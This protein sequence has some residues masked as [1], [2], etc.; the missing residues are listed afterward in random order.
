VNKL[1]PNIER[2]HHYHAFEVY[3]DL[4]YGR[5]YREVAR[6]IGSS[7]QSVCKWAKIYKWEDRLKECREVAESP[8]AD[9][10]VVKSDDPV[11]R[12]MQLLVEQTEALIDTVFQKDITGKIISKIKISSPEELI[13]LV[14][15][16]RK[17]LEAYYRFE[18]EYKPSKAADKRATKID[19]LTAVFMGGASQEERIA[20][21]ESLKNGNVPGRDSGAAGRLQEADYTE[22]PERGDAD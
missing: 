18:A 4:G 14:S 20:M 5:S 6:Q 21:M 3:R 10:A 7:A 13:R 22:V 17:M 15:E 9:G 11:L 19:K 16:Y 12:K 8:L 2:S 1:S